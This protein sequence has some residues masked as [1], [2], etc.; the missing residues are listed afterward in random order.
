MDRY[1]RRAAVGMLQYV[2]TALYADNE[3]A[4]PP[5]CGDELLAFDP[6]CSW[7][8]HTATR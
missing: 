6:W 8:S 5:K 1:N 3:K 7:H 4:K 2:V